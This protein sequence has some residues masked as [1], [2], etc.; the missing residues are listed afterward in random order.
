MCSFTFISAQKTSVWKRFIK[1]KVVE[2]KCKPKQ[3]KRGTEKKAGKLAPLNLDRT[4]TVPWLNSLATSG[5][6]CAQ[7][8]KEGMKNKS[9]ERRGGVT[10][11]SSAEVE[12][13]KCRRPFLCER[14]TH[15]DWCGRIS[16]AKQMC[17][18]CAKPQSS[19]KAGGKLHLCCYS[20]LFF[21]CSFL[22]PPK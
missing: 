22:H 1:N 9:R 8:W 3:N 13:K 15:T 21:H 11:L 17:F 14:M 19:T 2:V 10:R 20:F 6:T 5:T 12:T 16:P 7:R 18:S 4:Y